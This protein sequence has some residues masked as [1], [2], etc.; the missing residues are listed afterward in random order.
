MQFRQ[1]SSKQIK[2]DVCYHGSDIELELISKMHV[3]FAQLNCYG[4][5]LFEFELLKNTP[6]VYLELSKKWSETDTKK[7]K[8]ALSFNQFTF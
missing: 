4:R 7:F 1:L 2:A 8:R 3:C 5:L 6:S